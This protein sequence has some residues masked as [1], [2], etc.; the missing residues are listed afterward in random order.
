MVTIEEA[1]LM[2]DEIAQELPEEFYRQLNGGILLLPNA[3]AHP[4]ARGDGDLFIM[5]EYTHSPTLGRYI[6]IY[7]GS[8]ERVYAHLTPEAFKAQLKRV[9]VHEFTHHL[10]NLAGD[11]SLEHKDARDME[12]YRTRKRRGREQ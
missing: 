1:G 2:L 12:R 11:R 4:E 9:L 7:F 3:K 6:T 5:G 10:E 8:F